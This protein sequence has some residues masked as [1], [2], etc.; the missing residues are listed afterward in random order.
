MQKAQSNFLRRALF[1]CRFHPVFLRAWAA[2][3][4][5]SNRGHIGCGVDL[6][7]D[8][9]ELTLQVTGLRLRMY[10]YTALRKF[11]RREVLFSPVHVILLLARSNHTGYV[12]V[13]WVGY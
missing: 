13:M 7:T 9:D 6:V 10:E 11:T 4:N 1:S 3:L 8:V 5:E 12:L 2:P